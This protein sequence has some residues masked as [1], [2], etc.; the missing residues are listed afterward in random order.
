MKRH[1]IEEVTA[2]VAA[3][4]TI[5]WARLHGLVSLE[6]EGNF[7]SM[8]IDPVPLHEAELQDFAH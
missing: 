6:I 4:A 2:A 1:G 5:L 3:R 8:G 7:S